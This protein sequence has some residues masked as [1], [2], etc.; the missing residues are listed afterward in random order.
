MTKKRSSS[1]ALQKVE[2]LIFTVRG[3]KVILDGDLASIYGVTTA[4]LNQQVRRNADRFPEDF[5]FQL[6]KGEFDSLMLQ[7]ATSNEGRGGRRKPPLVFTEHGAIMAA[8]VLKTKRAVQM[9]VFVVRAFVRLRE[10]TLA[11]RD[12]AEKLKELE[13]TVGKHD[14]D[15]RTIV[16]AI[17]ELMKPPAKPVRQIGFRVEEPKA[18]YV[19]KRVSQR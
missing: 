3:M 5:V 17:R 15:I 9:S 2:S 4:R 19:A 12:L 10:L 16:K 1:T 8:N 14:A 6:T 7:N 11:H 13:Q 18:R